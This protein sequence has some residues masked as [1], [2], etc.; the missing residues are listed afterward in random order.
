LSQQQYPSHGSEYETVSTSD[1]PQAYLEEVRVRVW[2]AIDRER[3]PVAWSRS[4]STPRRMAIVAGAILLAVLVPRVFVAPSPDAAHL[5]SGG[6]VVAVLYAAML[7]ALV[8]AALAPLQALVIAPPA[9]VVAAGLVAPFAMCTLAPGGSVG[10]I[11]HVGYCFFIGLG[12]GWALILLLRGLDR[13]AHQDGVVAGLAVCVAGLAASFR[14]Q[15]DCT[16][17]GAMH[18]LLCHATIGGALLLQYV[19]ARGVAARLVSRRPR[20]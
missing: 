7:F 8:R 19:V 6:V 1:P 9:W 4:L 5:R 12:V 14:L 3:G 11:G 2:G 10:P 13:G 17:S 16:E 15:F 18:R 20:H